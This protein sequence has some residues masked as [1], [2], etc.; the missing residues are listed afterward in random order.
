MEQIKR[1]QE[2]GYMRCR[3]AQMRE[4]AAGRKDSLCLEVANQLKHL[5]QSLRELV[6][7]VEIHSKATGN[8]FAWA[9]IDEAKKALSA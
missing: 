9:E 7:I 3:E 4:I 5:K 2:Y 8:S 1:H 6:S